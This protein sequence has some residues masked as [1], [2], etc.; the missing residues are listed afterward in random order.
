M[1]VSCPAA[2]RAPA[3]A[4]HA[5]ARWQ[6]PACSHPDG[7]TLD[8]ASA[9]RRELQSLGHELP[10]DKK[11]AF[12]YDQSVLVRDSVKS[13]WEAIIFGLIL[14]VVIIYVFLKNWGTTLTAIIVIPVTVLVTVLAMSLLH[15]SFNLMTLGGI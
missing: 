14:S 11:L 4:I 10:P 2:A 15:M 12:F 5:S 7:S 1:P 8:I 3:T 13:V 9:L 6:C